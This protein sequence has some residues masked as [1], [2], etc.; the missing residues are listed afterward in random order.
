MYHPWPCCWLRGSAKCVGACAT[1][2]QVC[3][4]GP[5]VLKVVVCEHGC[6]GMSPGECL[7]YEGRGGLFRSCFR[8]TGL[9]TV[10]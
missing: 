10:M 1:G 4:C 9:L 2:M 3:T 6:G 5:S 8:T 7:E